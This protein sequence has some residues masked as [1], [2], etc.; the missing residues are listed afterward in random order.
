[1]WRRYRHWCRTRRVARSPLPDPAWHRA[2]DQPLF[3]YLD[4]KERQTLRFLAT[5]FSLEKPIV[6]AEAFSPSPPV[7]A[8]IAA[9]ACLLIL[10]LDLDWYREVTS[11]VLYPDDFLV[12]LS[13]TDDAGV[14][15]STVET[16][17]GEAWQRGPVVLS[18]RTV[19]D[20]L[21]TGFA[22]G[23]HVVVHEFA[24]QLDLLSGDANGCPPLHGGLSPARWQRTFA[25]A[26]ADFQRRQPPPFDDYA[27]EDPSEFFAVASECFFASP[28]TLANAYPEVYNLLVAFYRQDPKSRLPRA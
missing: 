8:T 14:I 27:G 15:H 9:Q 12:P 19:T 21:A 2:M 11:V 6:G 13:Y 25:A 26:F 3:R 4:A 24:H 22:T 10:A 17:S 18:W 28:H 7:V 5:A 23:Y 20:P 16:C 1:M